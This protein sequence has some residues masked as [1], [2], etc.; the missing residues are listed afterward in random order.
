V[1][2]PDPEPAEDAP[3]DHLSDADLWRCEQFEKLGYGDV[4]AL[5]LVAAGADYREAK[6]LKE[7][8]GRSLD[9]IFKYLT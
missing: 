5:L 7:E 9:W 3:W 8:K 6:R 4:P 1:A 2:K